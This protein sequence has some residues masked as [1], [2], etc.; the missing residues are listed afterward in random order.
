[1]LSYCSSPFRLASHLCSPFF[2]LLWLPPV[3]PRSPLPPRLLLP[4]GFPA[5]LNYVK[6]GRARHASL[7][8]AHV[9]PSF[10]ARLR[11]SRFL[12]AAAL[13]APNRPPVKLT[14]LPA[15]LHE[16]WTM[17]QHAQSA[18]PAGAACVHSMLYHHLRTNTHYFVAACLT[19]GPA[20]RFCCYTSSSGNS[21]SVLF[22]EF[23]RRQSPL[24]FVVFSRAAGEVHACGVRPGHSEYCSDATFGCLPRGSSTHY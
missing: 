8:C 13:T 5:T 24:F 17:A 15:A 22:F 2:L 23:F 19:H 4:P 10:C 20:W 11:E 7:C 21:R 12:R 14:P 1:M 16:S 9:A 3:R 6:L 18:T